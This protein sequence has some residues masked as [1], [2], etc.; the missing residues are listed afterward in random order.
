MELVAQG[1]G[2]VDWCKVWEIVF[3]AAVTVVLGGLLAGGIH[4]FYRRPKYEKQERILFELADLR[5]KGVAIRNEG[6]G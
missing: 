3:S 5:T 6:W 1:C 2:A 4:V